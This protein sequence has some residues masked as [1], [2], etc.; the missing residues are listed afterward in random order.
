ML[1][2]T[3]TTAV[4]CLS[5]K[6]TTLSTSL[7]GGGKEGAEITVTEG[8]GVND[9]A[10]LS[11]ENASKAT[12][13]VK[14]AV[15]KDK[16]CKEL[17]TKAG[18]VT[19]KEGKVPPSEEEKLEAGAVYYWQAEY[20][21]DSLDEASKSPCGK[22]VLTVKAKTSLS[23]I[24]AG[25]EE[26]ETVEGEE[27]T[28]TEGFE[29]KDK[30]TLSGTNASTATG[31]VKYLIFSDSE[32]KEL[33]VSAGEGSDEGTKVGS[34]GEEELE[35]EATYYW[36]A[37]Y[38]GDSLHQPSSTTCGKQF[39]LVRTFKYRSLAYP[40]NLE[41]KNFTPKEAFNFNGTIF[42][43][44]TSFTGTLNWPAESLK[45]KPSYS[46]CEAYSRSGPVYSEGCEYELAKPRKKGPFVF[47]ANVN[48][49]CP[50]P[51]QM[52]FYGVPP[53]MVDCD[54]EVGPQANIAK[55]E[56]Q[57]MTGPP[58]WLEVWPRLFNFAYAITVVGSPDC[59]LNVENRN[60]GSYAGT[61]ELK[62]VGG[63]EL[64]IEP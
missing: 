18:E 38:S 30:A 5:P 6:P 43:C 46:E 39:V 15:Y 34:S 52:Q 28:V 35:G 41:G 11:G 56:L 13:T 31:T 57:N 33:V 23:A 40:V 59:G 24:L 9:T 22:E 42:T 58:K 7:T 44:N 25:Q 49:V 47:V 36:Q 20:G 12:G 2:A 27:I 37:E 14:Y 62:A 60:D 8:T 32:C 53:S 55:F 19:V 54:V 45:L 10:T 4:A 63:G 61:F 16:E 50:P 64:F 3:A 51:K 29:V 26:E 21:G 1:A 17:V 48:I